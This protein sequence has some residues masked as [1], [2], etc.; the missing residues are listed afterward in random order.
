MSGVQT[1]MKLVSREPP[2]GKKHGLTIEDAVFW[3]DWTVTAA[4]AFC[5][6]M[7]GASIQH[8]PMDIV[9]VTLG[10]AVLFFGIA[11][12]P[13]VVRSVCYDGS[14]AIKGWVYVVAA[15]AVG[16]VIL[17][18]SVAAGVKTYG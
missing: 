10:I 9:T 18:S 1:F 14:G 7:I 15:D 3:I 4:V 12:F 5:A 11:V 13:V 2:P 6:A 17:M 8:K 16:I